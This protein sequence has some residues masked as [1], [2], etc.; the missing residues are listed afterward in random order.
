MA[1]LVLVVTQIEKLPTFFHKCHFKEE[2]TKYM[3][4]EKEREG[5][6]PKQLIGRL[7]YFVNPSGPIL[8]KQNSDQRRYF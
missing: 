7:F 6:Q 5:T 1:D 8:I 4:K 3:S 2:N